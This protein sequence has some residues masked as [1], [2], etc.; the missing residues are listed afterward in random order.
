MF[1]HD[2]LRSSI[3]G[4]TWI[5]RWLTK[6]CG[7]FKM[8]WLFRKLSKKLA[9]NQ[10]GFHGMSWSTLT[11]VVGRL[12][13]F[14]RWKFLFY[15][16]GVPLKCICQKAKNKSLWPKENMN[17]LDFFPS[18]REST[19]CGTFG[20]EPF[21]A[22][23]WKVDRAHQNYRRGWLFW[24]PGPG[25]STGDGWKFKRNITTRLLLIVCNHSKLV[26]FGNYF[27][28]GSIT[29]MNHC[30]FD[31]HISSPKRWGLNVS[32]TYLHLIVAS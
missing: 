29:T 24:V 1:D 2:D 9:T 14:F 32:L 12:L 23:L 15:F 4:I 5:R 19:M 7:S 28:E 6:R 10:S 16:L 21:P 17:K 20:L 30:K 3:L 25:R 18:S 31:E 27:V 13:S 8:G 26:T 22:W 11:K